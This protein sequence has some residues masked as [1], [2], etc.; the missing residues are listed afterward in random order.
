MWLSMVEQLH[1]KLAQKVDTLNRMASSHPTTNKYL[2]VGMVSEKRRL[3]MG[4]NQLLN[5]A[6]CPFIEIGNREA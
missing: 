3:I 5:L 6:K 2:H 4:E 1:K